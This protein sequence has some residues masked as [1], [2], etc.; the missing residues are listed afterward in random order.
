MD[1]HPAPRHLRTGWG[2][3]ALV[4][5]DGARVLFDSGPRPDLLAHNSRTLGVDLR[6]IDYVVLS[7]PHRDHYGGLSYVARVRPGV[8][9][10]IPSG[11]DPSFVSR[12]R[13]MGLFPA[14]LGRPTRLAG[15]LSTTGTLWGPPAEHGLVI[16]GREGGLLI[17][18]CAHPGVDA[19]ALRAASIAEGRL[20]GVVGGFHLLSAD[21]HRLEEVSTGL[22]ALGVR[23]LAPIH[24][25]GERARRHLRTRLSDAYLD[26]GVGDSIELSAGKVVVTRAT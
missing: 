10:F 12:L 22:R 24:C 7:H 21:Y 13:R 2:L 6:E 5:S 1:N 4:E 16:V 15:S 25:S 19:L 23:F 18:G 14:I 11:C 8:T 17:T 9:V 3:S 20:L 26:V